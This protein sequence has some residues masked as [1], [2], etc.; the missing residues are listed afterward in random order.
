MSPDIESR[1]TAMVV[2]DSSHALCDGH[3]PD[4]PIVPGVTMLALCRRAASTLPGPRIGRLIAVNRMR[5][6]EPAIPPC[7][8]SVAATVVTNTPSSTRV[9]FVIK[10]NGHRS[11]SIDAEWA[12]TDE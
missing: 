4:S 6:T 10:V 5:F 12:T 8:I 9:K 3:F 2:V 1:A 11:G 7:Q